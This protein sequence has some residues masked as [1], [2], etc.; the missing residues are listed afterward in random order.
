M[1]IA[2]Y[3]VRENVKTYPPVAENVPPV[4][5]NLASE[6]SAS[7]AAPRITKLHQSNA[8]ARVLATATDSLKAKP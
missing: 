1:W 2:H 6:V 5:L 7:P 4:K 3:D 8:R